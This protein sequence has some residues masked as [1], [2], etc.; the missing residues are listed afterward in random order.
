ML[1]SAISEVVKYGH[2]VHNYTFFI[3]L[4]GLF[5][6]PYGTV[7]IYSLNKNVAKRI[8]YLQ[9]MATHAFLI[10]IFVQKKEPH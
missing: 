9:L 10:F 6:T 7:D 8:E 2:A 3:I 1:E 5:P 4:K